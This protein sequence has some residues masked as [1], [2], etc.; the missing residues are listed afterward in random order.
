MAGKKGDIYLGILNS[1]SLISPFGRKLSIADEEIGREQRTASGRLVR[2]ITA[3]K[4]KIVLA[5]ET[6]DGDALT[7]FID[8]Y[9]LYSELSILLYHTDVPGTTDD[10]GQYYDQYTVLMAPIARERLLLLADGLWTGVQIELR[11]C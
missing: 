5:Y 1:E 6:I 4:K 8:L 2:D 9:F 11:E 3:V 10:E 7:A